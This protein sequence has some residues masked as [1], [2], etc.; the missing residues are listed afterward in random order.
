M[1]RLNNLLSVL[2]TNPYVSGATT[3]FLVLYAGL[4]APAL[5]S[6]IVGLFEH[7]VFKFLVMVMVLALVKGKD[8][9]VALLVVIGF[10]VSMATLSRYR[11][12]SMGRDL[13]TSGSNVGDRERSVWSS[14][15]GVNHLNIRGYSYIDR[16]EPNHLPGGHGDMA[17]N[18]SI[19]AATQDPNGY[20]GHDYASIGTDKSQL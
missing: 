12:Y 20:D 3:L 1:D 9:R 13:G 16:D 14:K 2:R 18:N 15:D 4:A 5:P 17:T 10:V 11:A 6:S 7:S 19:L 8:Y